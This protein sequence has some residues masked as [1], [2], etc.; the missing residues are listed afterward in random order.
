MAPNA[1]MHRRQCGRQ[2]NAHRK[3]EVSNGSGE[4]SGVVPRLSAA[5]MSSGPSLFGLP[6]SEGD[7]AAEFFAFVESEN[8][9]LNWAPK[10]ADTKRRVLSEAQQDPVVYNTFRMKVCNGKE[11]EKGSLAAY[12]ASAQSKSSAAESASSAAT[13]KADTTVAVQSGKSSEE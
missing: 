6:P 2:L 11:W 12:T 9:T 4:N 7:E 10:E 3:T 5:D 8:Q 13:A 1:R